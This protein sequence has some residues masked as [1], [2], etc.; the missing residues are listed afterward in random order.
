MVLYHQDV[1]VK[2]GLGGG[3]EVYDAEMA[4]LMMGAK[5]ACKL[6]KRKNSANHI[7]LF[8]DNT[9]AVQ[10]IFDP[11]PGPSQLYAIKTHRHLTRFLDSHPNNQV[12]I[13]WCPGHKNIRGN[14][15]ADKLAKEARDRACEA[16]VAHTTSH[17]RRKAKAATGATWRREWRST[18]KTGGYATANHI[19]PS[20]SPSKTFTR[21]PREVFGRLVQCRTNHGYTGEFRR[22]FFPDEDFS[23]P[24]GEEVQ[25]REHI[26]TRCP[27]YNNKRSNLRKISRDLW[28]PVIL[29]TKKG[30]AALTVFLQESTAFTRDGQQPKKPPIPTFEN[31]PDDENDPDP[32]E[33]NP[34]IYL[35]SASSLLPKFLLY[36]PACS[37]PTSPEERMR[38]CAPAPR[39]L[40]GK[41]A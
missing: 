17:A 3:A 34:E 29:G 37:K 39:R 4:G 38:A 18:Q 26:V 22:R 11:K 41:M 9:S 15:R 12:T 21:T 40:G 27:L 5:A 33:D 30:I 36:S 25:T 23:C 13:A 10:S 19:P 24:C 14:E 32:I 7:F 16:H 31:E 6:A 35:R 8:A 1:E 28:L 2:T 20:S